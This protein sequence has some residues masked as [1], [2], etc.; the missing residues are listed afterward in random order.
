MINYE[1][2]VTI[3]R[4]ENFIFNEYNHLPLHSVGD[5]QNLRGKIDGGHTKNLFLKN[6]K[7]ELFLFSCHEETMINL[8]LLKQKLLLGNISFASEDYLTNYLGVKPGAV[9]PFGLLNDINN[10]IIFYLDEKLTH[11]ETLNFHPL[12]NTKTININTSHFLIFMKK[13]KKLVKIINFDTYTIK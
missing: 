5:S 6:K 9:T 10:K 1:Q 7:N 12:I 4:N 8:K 2:L 3:L 13:N 11:Y